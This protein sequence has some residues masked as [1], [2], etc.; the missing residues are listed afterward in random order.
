[1]GFPGQESSDEDSI[2]VI[3]RT[4]DQYSYPLAEVVSRI[5][6]TSRGN[7]DKTGVNQDLSGLST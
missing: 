4:S 7:F 2:L 1:V 3:E 5:F 6:W